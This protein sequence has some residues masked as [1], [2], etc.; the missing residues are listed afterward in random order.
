MNVATSDM[1]DTRRE[2][3]ASAAALEIRDGEN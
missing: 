1:N 3:I 2:L